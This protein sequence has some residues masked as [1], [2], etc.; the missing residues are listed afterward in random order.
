MAT[1]TTEDRNGHLRTT[2]EL[3]PGEQVSLCRCFKS[4]NFPFC[5]GAHKQEPTNVG[6]V[7]VNMAAEKTQNATKA[8]A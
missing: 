4:K 3:Q 2:V 1:H 6:P 5:D 8:V 7:R